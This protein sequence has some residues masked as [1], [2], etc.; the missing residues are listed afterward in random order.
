MVHMVHILSVV[1]LFV[2]QLFIQQYSL[3]CSIVMQ[4]DGLDLTLMSSFSRPHRGCASISTIAVQ[5]SGELAKRPSADSADLAQ[6][7]NGS[8]PQSSSKAA[9]G[10][11]AVTPD[12]ISNDDHATP[13][14]MEVDDD[15][16]FEK[17]P[18]KPVKPEPV[19][20]RLLLNSWQS[21]FRPM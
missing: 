7:A 15:A 11:G 8:N 1:C 10:Q 6:A 12:G 19:Q 14:P 9:A 16:M 18:Q 2:A 17:K 20:V 3:R 4:C 5:G 13:L 21:C